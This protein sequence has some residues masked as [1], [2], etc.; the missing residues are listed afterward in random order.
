VQA[1]ESGGQDRYLI[2]EILAIRDPH[3]IMGGSSGGGG[4]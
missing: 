1:D 4:G 2:K 3:Q